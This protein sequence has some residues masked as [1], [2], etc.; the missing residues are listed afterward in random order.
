MD[1]DD[2]PTFDGR[3]GAKTQDGIETTGMSSAVPT[4]PCRDGAKTQDGIETIADPD[5]D[6]L[7]RSRRSEN[8]GRD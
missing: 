3:D 8:P 7:Q 2:P 6:T 1:M 4:S 5:L